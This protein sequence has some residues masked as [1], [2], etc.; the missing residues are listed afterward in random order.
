MS[1]AVRQH[2]KL[3][4]QGKANTPPPATPKTPA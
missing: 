2:Y 4:T 1:D 3:A